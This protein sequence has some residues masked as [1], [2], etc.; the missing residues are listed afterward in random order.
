M[1]L[2]MSTMMLMR[3]AEAQQP[4]RSAPPGR[5]RPHPGGTGRSTVRWATVLGLALAAIQIAMVI[6]ST[7][8]R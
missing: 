3:L 1:S 6:A 5:P 7:G 8:D 4:W 2:P